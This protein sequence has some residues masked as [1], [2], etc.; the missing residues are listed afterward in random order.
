MHVNVVLQI[1]VHYQP[2]YLV[3][4]KFFVL[5]FEVVVGKE[6]TVS[7]SY[8]P[9]VDDSFRVTDEEPSVIREDQAVWMHGIDQ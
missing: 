3:S 7:H 4:F 1:G 9:P 5:N 2:V 6:M 8:G